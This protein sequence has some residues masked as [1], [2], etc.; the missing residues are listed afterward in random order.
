MSVWIPVQPSAGPV[1]DSIHGQAGRGGGSE[2][3][4]AGQ[5]SGIGLT[6]DQVSIT[7]KNAHV[8]AMLVERMLPSALADDAQQYQFA[9]MH[10]RIAV[11]GLV[12]ILRGIVWVHVVRHR[13][14]V[15]QEIRR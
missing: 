5:L 8:V 2:E 10:V 13:A 3:R 6:G 11:V 15:D 12:R 7:R 9:R 14:S 1:E 4:R